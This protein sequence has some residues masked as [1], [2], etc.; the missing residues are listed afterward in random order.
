MLRRFTE[1]PALL[2]F[3]PALSHRRLTSLI[4]SAAAAGALAACGG[5]GSSA[6]PANVAPAPAPA[7]APSAGTRLKGSFCG[8]ITVT[9]T[10]QNDL[11]DDLGLTIPSQG[12]TEVYNLAAFTFPTV[13]APGALMPSP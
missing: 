8:P 5:G 7:P 4:A 9:V 13:P 3:D 1:E 10:L 12:T 2:H 6:D 11:A